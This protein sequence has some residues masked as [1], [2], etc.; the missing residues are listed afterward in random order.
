MNGKE[1]RSFSHSEILT[2]I[3]YADLSLSNVDL[4][5]IPGPKQKT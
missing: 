2:Y 5:R 1:L 4:D 3:A